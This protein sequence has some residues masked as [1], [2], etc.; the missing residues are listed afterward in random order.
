[1]SGSISSSVTIWY[2][3]LASTASAA[4]GDYSGVV[5]QSLTFNP[6]A[7][8]TQQIVIPTLTHAGSSTESAETFSVGLQSTQNGNAFTSASATIQPNTVAPTF[9]ITGPGDVTAGDNT[10]LTLT[11][12]HT[13]S[14]SVTI[15]YSTLS[16]T[17]SAADG[18]YSGVVN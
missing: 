13:I 8:N 1:M 7:S 5:N 10:S 18:D 15:C 9:S 16:S 17:A 11:S 12:S 4:D 3:T 2:S 6:G 14:S